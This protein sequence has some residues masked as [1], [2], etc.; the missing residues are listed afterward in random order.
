MKS[1][2]ALWV[3]ALSVLIAACA[4]STAY[5]GEIINVR[6]GSHEGFTRIVIEADRPIEIDAFMLADPTP[7]LVVALPGAIWSVDQLANGQGRGHGLLGEFRFEP[8]GQTPR[9]VF[10]LD[11]PASVMRTMTLAPDGGGHRMVIDVAEVSQSEFVQLAGFP[12]S[13]RT[14]TELLAEHADVTPAL[15][16]CRL[17][18]IAIDPGHGGRDPGAPS[19]HGGGDEAD[20]N[21]AAALQL[22]EIL[23][24]SGRYD[25]VLTR[26]SD[27]FIELE[28]RL[29]IAR[30]AHAD[31]FISLH[32]DA[33]EGSSSANGAA[34]YVLSHSGVNRSRTRAQ[35]GGDWFQPAADRPEMVGDILFNISMGNKVNQSRQFATTLLDEVSDV[36]HLHRST[37]SERGF[38]VLLDAQFP[39]VLF[40]MGFLSNRSDARNLNNAR[41][42]QELMQALATALDD[43]FPACNG[44]QRIRYAAADTGVA[45][46]SR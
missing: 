27:I 18:L 20:V 11:S 37:P 45:T 5:A 36:T 7:R 13:H 15:A 8:S 44:E 23:I 6:F 41:H 31:M 25:V 3:K 4:A 12:D 38:L 19:R 17:P 42:R 30:A 34:A 29:R 9:L 10:D 26:E 21:L 24:N 32:A 46:R 22:K 35:R 16:Q 43:H 40:E 33:V 14:L 28:D 2:S 1:I 39:A